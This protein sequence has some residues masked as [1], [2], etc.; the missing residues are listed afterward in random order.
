MPRVF[1]CLT[2]FVFR[3]FLCFSLFSLLPLVFFSLLPSYVFFLLY[4][5]V[6][7]HLMPLVIIE[8]HTACYI[9]STSKCFPH[10]V[11]YFYVNVHRHQLFPFCVCVMRH[12]F[13]P[14][15]VWGVTMTGKWQ[16]SATFFLP[17]P[18][19][20]HYYSFSSQQLAWIKD[21]GCRKADTP[22]PLRSLS[23]KNNR[24]HTDIKDRNIP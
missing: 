11:L 13:A 2:S 12:T 16:N 9:Q 19:S 21:S 14:F 15:G 18:F 6:Y 10:T 23:L 8:F 5:L 4:S 7:L 22:R 20:P 24:I 1:G 3:Y 17:H